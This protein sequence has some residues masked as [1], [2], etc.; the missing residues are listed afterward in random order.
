MAVDHASGDVR[1]E[2]TSNQ[3]CF[4]ILPRSRA[5]LKGRVESRI[6]WSSAATPIGR[7]QRV[8]ICRAATAIRLGLSESSRSPPSRSWSSGHY[9]HRLIPP[10]YCYPIDQ[11]SLPLLPYPLTV[12]SPSLLERTIKFHIYLVSVNFLGAGFAWDIH[13]LD[14]RW[15]TISKVRLYSP[16]STIATISPLHFRAIML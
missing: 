4:S 12:D 2:L 5:G 10:L 14:S 13:P 3:S 1:S 6:A 11:P 7:A 8:S 16:S 9:L 15:N